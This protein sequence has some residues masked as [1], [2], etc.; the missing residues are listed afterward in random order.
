M[1]Q[2]QAVSHRH[3]ELSEQKPRTSGAKGF[4]G[5]LGLLKAFFLEMEKRQDTGRP[6]LILESP[7]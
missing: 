3:T 7:L 4:R 1:S 2:V 6:N 5:K